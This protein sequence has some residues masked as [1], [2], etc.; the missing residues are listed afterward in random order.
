MAHLC[1]HEG[2]SLL[3]VLYYDC[4][5]F[6]GEVKLPVSGN[7]YT[8]AGSDKWLRD[9]AAKDLFA[10]RRGV[11][12][13]RGYKPKKVPVATQALTDEDFAPDFEQ[14]GVDMRIGLDM[15]NFAADRTVDRIILVTGDT[16]CV[17]A[18]KN[19]RIRGLQVVLA[20]VPP[21][22]VAAEL[23]W[24]SDFERTVGWP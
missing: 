23:L 7:P 20:S 17:P 14:K 10:V 21:N 3:R 8:F 5:P 16:D 15:A 9:L 24:H 11:L 6:N 4:P 12:K 22:S 18:M 2:E 19:C 1:V 13:F